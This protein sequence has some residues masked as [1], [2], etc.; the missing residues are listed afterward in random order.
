MLGTNTYKNYASL[1][2]FLPDGEFVAFLDIQAKN[3]SEAINSSMGKS[4]Q[5]VKCGTLR[6]NEHRFCADRS[7]LQ[8]SGA[9]EVNVPSFT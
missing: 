1:D 4:N 5:A 8:T 6:R 2:N 9:L 3:R 7:F